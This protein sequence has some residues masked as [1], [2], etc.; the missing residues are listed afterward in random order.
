M[1]IKLILIVNKETKMTNSKI[2]QIAKNYKVK[3]WQIADKLGMQ[4]SNF[5]K[6]LRKQLSI[7]DENKIIGII[8]ELKGGLQ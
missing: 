8:Q 2:K 6:M 3:L 1:I 5:S 4:D 7:Q